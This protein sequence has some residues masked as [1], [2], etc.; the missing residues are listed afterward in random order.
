MAWT[1]QKRD[2]RV[3]DTVTNAAYLFAGWVLFNE[4]LV[5]SDVSLQVLGAAL[6]VLSVGS[7]AYHWTR[8]EKD[9]LADEGGMYLVLGALIGHLIGWPIAATVAFCG[10]LMALVGRLRLFPTTGALVA[11]ALVILLIQGAFLSS[12][13][14]AALFLASLYVRERYAWGHSVWHCG[15]ALAVGA[16]AL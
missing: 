16:A 15:T 4:G 8:L 11:I 6:A 5:T 2:W 13:V 10:L 12:G 14:A 3:P 7:G 9:L 1:T